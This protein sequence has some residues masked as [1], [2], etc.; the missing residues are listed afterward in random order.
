MIW[1]VA[2]WQDGSSLDLIP[3]SLELAWTTFNASNR[4]HILAKYLEEVRSDYDLILIDCAPTESVLSTA[5][6]HAA[7]YVFVP[8]KLEFLSTLGLPL[9]LKSMKEFG[10]INGEESVPEFGG[11]ILNDT[12]DKLEHQKSRQAIEDS[13]KACSW[14]I[15]KNSLSHSESYPAGARLG[16]PIFMTDKARSTKKHELERV[17]DEFLARIGL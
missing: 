13:A 9:L 1:N 10:S 2:E 14:P 17:G 5:A 11:I 4:A 8:V 7:D 16:K 15:F 12:M 6:Y 3:S